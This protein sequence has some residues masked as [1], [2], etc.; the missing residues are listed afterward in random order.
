MKKYYIGLLILIG[1]PLTMLAQQPE[2]PLKPLPFTEWKTSGGWQTAGSI[3]VNPFTNDLQLTSG[4]KIYVGN[5]K[6]GQLETKSNFQECQLSFDFVLSSESESVFY[7]W[8]KQG[9]VLSSE[10]NKLGEL[11]T[12]DGQAFAP[13]TYAGRAPGLWQ[14]MEVAVRRAENV[15]NKAL[16]EYVKINGLKVLQ[17]VFVDASELSGPMVFSNASGVMAIRDFKLLNFAD[18]KPITVKNIDYKY[19]K[20]I[21]EENQKVAE[22]STPDLTGSMKLLHHDVGQ[23]RVREHFLNQYEISIDVAKKG[24][25]AFLLDYTGN[26][27]LSV[28]GKPLIEKG[29]RTGRFPKFAYVSLEK[30]KH[31]LQL[32]YIKAWWGAQLGLF[33]TGDG[34]RPYPVHALTSLSEKRMAGEIT[35]NPTNE[36]E[37]IRS[38]FMHGDEKQTH[39]VSVGSPQGFHYAFDLSQG[40]LLAV[41][42]GEFANVTEMWYQRGE[43]QILQP[44][45]LG[46]ALSGKPM[47]VSK[48]EKNQLPDSYEDVAEI[49]YQTMRF[50]ENEQPSF[51]HEFKGQTL[52]QTII[53]TNEGLKHEVTIDGNTDN[54]ILRIAEGK[55]IEKLDNG[56][57]RVDD[58]YVQLSTAAGVEIV[59]NTDSKTIIVPA[60]AKFSYSI[61]W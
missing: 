45:G 28:D 40:A 60:K 23:G 26:V 11:K 18:I 47:L 55:S 21:D 42:K 61:I 9:I 37:V 50:D 16:I 36:T 41:W 52:T 35:V 15:P 1:M 48:S 22:G 8:G 20:S 5:G 19:Y 32:E 38:F 56:T 54:L 53:P 27:A 29:E 44:K 4:D 34:I 24:N 51:V 6:G 3:S 14:H 58:Y 43:P 25:Y 12:K 7:V 2:F 57:F 49:N 10:K 46:I 17:N 33:I 30:G 13:L 39:V 31:Q 59:N